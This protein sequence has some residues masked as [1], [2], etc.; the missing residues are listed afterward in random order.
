[1]LLCLINNFHC[2]FYP[3]TRGKW[4]QLG[5]LAWRVGSPPQRWASSPSSSSSSSALPLLPFAMAVK[6]EFQLPHLFPE[7]QLPAIYP[8]SQICRRF[9]NNRLAGLK[10][11]STTLSAQQGLVRPDGQCE[12]EGVSCLMV[13]SKHRRKQSPK[14]QGRRA[15]FGSYPWLS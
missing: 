13:S 10:P 8:I 6:G 9:H 2:F 1:M 15:S 14:V 12:I 7:E 5:W 4:L 11:P 3:S